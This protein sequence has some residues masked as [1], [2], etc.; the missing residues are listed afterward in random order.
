MRNE[1]L[2]PCR[3]Q[4]TPVTVGVGQGPSLVLEMVA[5]RAGYPEARRDAI[6]DKVWEPATAFQSIGSEN[7]W[8]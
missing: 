8:S 3:G 4:H 7:T 1:A 6:M 2:R 5:G